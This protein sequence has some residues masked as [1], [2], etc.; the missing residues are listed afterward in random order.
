MVN[1]NYCKRRLQ[2]ASFP[3]VLVGPNSHFKAT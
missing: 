2:L 1:E 3:D